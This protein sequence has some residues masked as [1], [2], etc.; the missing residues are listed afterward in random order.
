MGSKENLSDY[1]GIVEEG[2]FRGTS[3]CFLEEGLDCGP[4]YCFQHQSFLTTGECVRDATI[5]AVLILEPE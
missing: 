4:R 5:R 1:A 2:L 3:C